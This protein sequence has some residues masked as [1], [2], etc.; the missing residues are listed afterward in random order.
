MKDFY[1]DF[2]QQR[3]FGEVLNATFAFFRL[4][5]GKLGKAILFYTCPFLI[6]QGMAR[7]Y[8]N[9][10]FM[11][12]SNIL[13]KQGMGAIFSHFFTSTAMLLLTTFLSSLMANLTVYSYIKAYVEKGLNGFTLD[14]VWRNLK[15]NFF[16][17]FLASLVTGV[18]LFIG[19]IM[20][21]VPG[22]YLYVSFSFIIIIMMYEG[23]SFRASFKRSFSL[24]HYQWW[25]VFLLILV[26]YFILYIV[27]LLF[28]IPQTIINSAYNLNSL[29][30]GNDTTVMKYLMIVIT[31]LATLAW[32]FI[33]CVMFIALSF[34]YYSIIEKKE[35]PGLLKEIEEL[36]ESSK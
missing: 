28:S 5:I 34:K 21:F 32:G 2:R 20:C 13:L 17:V 4:N 11:T 35:S 29:D 36:E 6:I 19:F 27:S 14:D 8:Y 1:I 33:S 26:V 15:Q 23:K 24:A 9:L 25:S 30:P 7:V 12:L 3:D 18:L 16:R 31:M 22:I 10:S